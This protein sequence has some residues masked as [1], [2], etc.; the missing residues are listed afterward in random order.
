MV[1]SWYKYNE[2]PKKRIF[3]DNEII[4]T[5]MKWQ[6]AQLSVTC[7]HAKEENLIHV[8]WE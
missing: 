2:N 1:A 6:I 3:N 8:K 4:K 5:W 7:L